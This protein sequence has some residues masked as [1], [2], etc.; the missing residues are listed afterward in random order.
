MQSKRHRR[1]NGLITAFHVF[2][3]SLAA[4]LVSL[5]PSESFAHPMGNFSI[6]HYAEITINHDSLEVLYLIDMAEIPTFQDLQGTGISAN[7]DDSRLQGYLTSKS[8]EFASGLHVTV[9]GHNVLLDPVSQNAIFPP[10]AGGLPTMKFGFLYRGK[11]ACKINACSVKYEDVNFSGRAGWKEVVVKA[12]HNV[13]LIDSSVPEHD[14]SAQLTNYPTDLVNSPPQTLEAAITFS[15][16]TVAATSTP[17]PAAV[18]LK[19]AKVHSLKHFE[20]PSKIGAQNAMKVLPASSTT[21]VKIV[22]TPNRQA[23]PRSA[24]TQMIASQKIG[25]GIALLAGLIA[26]GLGGLHALEPGHG[27]TIVA[28]YLVGTR[29]TARHAFILGMIVTITHTAGVYLLG[30]VTLYAQRYILPEK[31]YPF[32]GVLSGILIAGMG[33]YLFLQRLAGGEMAF[34]HKHGGVSHDHVGLLSSTSERGN[35][36][37]TTTGGDRAKL[38]PTRIVP[39]RQL[40]ILGITGG[41]VPCP[42]ALVVLLSAI[43]LHRLFFG[44]FLIV[45]FSVGLA[46]V[47]IAMGMIAVYAGQLL[48]RFRTEGPLMQRWLPVS[49]ALMITILGTAI[50]VRG[51]MAA[52]IV[53][54]HL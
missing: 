36:R 54:I 17:Q 40:L 46:V 43:A 38:Q 51:L 47:L 49:S 3:F 1:A 6:N 26:V 7:S 41:I 30:V 10:G 13:S 50:T 33:L 4:L 25:L 32:L 9:D 21:P 23:T 24:F 22:V 19:P 45:A 37:A 5:C 12:G 29:G 15:S 52:G 31:L 20:G 14:R 53:H 11:V 44:L 48:S 18:K 35:R 8:K 28:A 42:A 2:S 39:A 27:K 34:S 16:Q